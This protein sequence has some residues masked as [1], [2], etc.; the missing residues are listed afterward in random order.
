LSISAPE[1]REIVIGF[2][3]AFT[4]AD[5]LRPTHTSRSGRVYQPGLGPH[6]ED[7]AVALVLTQLHALPPFAGLAM[8]QFLPYPHAPRQKCDV[9]IGDPLAWAIE[10]KM[11]RFRGDNGK[12]D[13]TSIKDLLS[14]YES[15]RSAL[16]DTAK[17]ARAGFPG[18]AAVLIYGFDYPDRRLDPAINAFE[19]LARELVTL[20][21]RVE[22]PLG[23][24]VHPVHADGRAFGWQVQ[25]LGP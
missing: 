19:T 4:R 15:D 13:D 14:P 20:G 22:A 10:V 16:T 1:L 6:A 12:P 2:A 8:G 9:W 11:A 24:L 3:E 5:A 18:R 17:L 23:Q 21:D 7:R 25:P